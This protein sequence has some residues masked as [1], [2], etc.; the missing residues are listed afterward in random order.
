MAAKTSSTLLL[1]T[2]STLTLITICFS[3]GHGVQLPSYAAITDHENDAASPY[4]LLSTFPLTRQ[5]HGSRPAIA[6]AKARASASLRLIRRISV[7]KGDATPFSIWN[8]S[9]PK[10]DPIRWNADVP[11][12]LGKSGGDGK[13]SWVCEA[14]ES[15]RRHGKY[16]A[17]KSK[18]RKLE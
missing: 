11:L 13:G 16:L 4:V 2:Y 18:T 17:T 8:I 9:V 14:D 10:K 5:Y 7:G 12:N 6:A 3:L 1:S 15:G